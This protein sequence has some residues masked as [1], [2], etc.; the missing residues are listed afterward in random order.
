MSEHLPD[1]SAGFLLL[2]RMADLTGFA[3]RADE[4]QSPRRAVSA[5]ASV[6]GEIDI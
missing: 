6:L 4:R 3:N 2:Q 5:L 1:A